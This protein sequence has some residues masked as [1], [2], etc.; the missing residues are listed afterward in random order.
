MI[1]AGQ[2]TEFTGAEQGE[3]MNHRAMQFDADTEESG[4]F[5]GFIVDMLPGTLVLA[6]AGVACLVALVAA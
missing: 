2:R 3:D 5:A 4:G 6:V 1:V